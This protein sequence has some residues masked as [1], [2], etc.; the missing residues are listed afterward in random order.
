ME[1]GRGKVFVEEEFS[2]LPAVLADKG[3]AIHG[4]RFHLPFWKVAYLLEIKTEA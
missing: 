2:F 1:N 3:Y 4:I